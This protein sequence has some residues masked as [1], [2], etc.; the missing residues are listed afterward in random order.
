MFKKYT[1]IEDIK[2]TDIKA[3][4]TFSNDKY[5]LMELFTNKDIEQ[6]KIIP[7]D[8]RHDVMSYGNQNYIG[9]FITNFNTIRY[10]ALNESENKI[11]R[12]CEKRDKKGNLIDIFQYTQSVCLVENKTQY[13]ILNWDF[14]FKYDKYPEIYLGFTDQHETIT[15]YII[16]KIILVLNQTLNLKKKQLEYIWAEKT[17]SIGYH[18]YWNGIVVNKQLHQY[19][20]NKTMDI[21][22]GEKK[23]P[24][25]LINQIFDSCTSKANGLRLFYFKIDE[26]Y[27]F[28]SESKSTLKFDPDP[29]K[30]FH[31]CV[32]NT[33]YS[34]FNFDLKISQELI[35]QAIWT[36]DTKIKN[37]DIKN[38][39]V[40][41]DSEYLTDFVCLDLEN[42]KDLF[43]GLTNIIDL[44]R[45]DDY[46]NWISLV[47]LHKNYNLKENIIELSKKSKKFDSKALK[48]IESIFD[49]KT[50]TNKNPIT[51][52]TLIKWAK[53]D[54]L[55]KTN[56]IFIKYFLT[57]KLDVKSIDEVL[58][59]NSKI[60]PN[61]SES[62]QYISSDALTDMIKNINEGSI[63]ALGI[64]A[65]TGAGKTTLCVGIISN[66]IKSNPKYTILSV[67]TR[68]SMSAC[69]LNA[70]NIAK[71][72]IKFSSYLDE[73]I[74]SIDYFISSLE[75]L[76][77]VNESYDVVILDEINS[78]INYF[79][80][81]TLSNRR[82]QC[83]GNL[84]K[85]LSKAKLIIGMDGNITDMVWTMLNQLGRKIYYYKNTFQNKLNIPL[86]IYN[87]TG[88]NEDNNLITWC[89]KF[90]IP[91]YISKS[92]SC[93]ILSD[94]KEITDKL[95][96]I[97]IKSNPN[98]DYYRIFTREEGTLED[99]KNIN[100]VGLNRLIYA[101]PKFIYGIDITIE[102]DEIFLIYRRTSGLVS[103]GALEMCQQM[104][105]ARKT[106]GVNLLGLDPV[107]KYSFNQ[108]ID[109][110]TNKKIQES[111]I[112]SYSK[113]HDDQ[114]KKYN[115]IN[116]MGCTTIGSD[117]NI[118]FTSDSFMTQ[119]HYLKTWYD[120][121]F[122]R[123]KIDIIKLVAKDYGYKIVEQD[124][125]PDIKYGSSLKSK[126]AL[127][128]EE[129]I[130][131][132]K[133]IYLGLET[134]PQYKYYIDN[135]KEQIKMR[136]KYLKNIDDTN[137]HIELACDPD[138]FV[139][140]INKKYMQ[141]DKIEFEKKQIELNNSEITHVVKDNDLYNKINTCFWFEQILNFTRYKINDI[142][143]K[144][145]NEIK[146]I[147]SNNIDKFYCIYKN[148]ACRER[149]IKLIK[150]KIQ[151]ISSLNLLQKFITDCYN[152]IIEDSIKYEYK[153]IYIKR[154][155]I[156]TIFVFFS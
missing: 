10:L 83:V 88:Y 107:S 27:Y 9:K 79:Y 126:L 106:K 119:I 140:W 114:C 66:L 45:I 81:S 63:N 12:T 120:Q 1:N 33:N 96:L 86:N 131:L 85:I 8:L 103:M 25:E 68:R 97:F 7:Q 113:F 115:I 138:K 69:H 35:E 67:I 32:L 44:K 6:L 152:G 28:P 60:K 37:K 84:I 36:I 87:C 154:K 57:L 91:N 90:I 78:L 135:L 19:I 129:I 74:E 145:I 125:N 55:N 82:L 15:K 100:Q 151:G 117:G 39:V 51:L 54:D 109:F 13:Y 5:Y 11:Y 53:E 92:K 122:Y 104:A 147:F 112:N 141:M 2:E 17:Q 38:N 42:K 153:K 52:G 150:N 118:K 58:L 61:W 116:E 26:D 105:R 136:E 75:F 127:K 142:K 47:F 146:K 59:A 77:N 94:S 20:F 65:G 156:E 41:P 3:I 121:L 139:N 21:I 30:H 123:N 110:E 43:I 76:I 14:D 22:K 133:Q 137:L 48:T 70:F 64:H 71:S 49:N 50:K 4:H 148:N 46:H 155:Y 89:D 16:D 99:M 102:Y 80:S 34:N 134:P 124:W 144:D 143:C 149:I 128:K 18:I 40:K 130:E 62:T 72:P 101:S 93:L 56:K 31:L 108:Y 132:S 95:K 98:E 29:Y 111:Y 24:V 23:Y 73:S